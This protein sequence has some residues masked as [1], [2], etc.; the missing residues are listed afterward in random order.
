MIPNRIFGWVPQ[1]RDYRDYQLKD[2]LLQLPPLS[3]QPE[4]NLS[5]WVPSAYNQLNLGSCT[6][7][8][9]A[10]VLEFLLKKEGKEV[11]TPSRLAIYYLER[12]MEKTIN[13]DAGAIIRDGIKAC[14]NNGVFPE[15]L[16]PYLVDKF[17]IDPPKSCWAQAKHHKI[18][19]YLSVEPTINGI[20]SA[21]SLGY[22]VVFG[23]Q[24][25]S[26]F[27]DIKS[28]GIMSMPSGDY[29]GGHCVWMFGNS[30]SKAIFSCQN[31]WGTDWADNGKF[32]MPYDY[33]QYLSD[34]WTVRLLS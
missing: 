5:M 16:W 22:P 20:K 19:E 4:V 10:G 31:S 14:A 2:L 6:G 33:I 11:F 27:M 3:L 28:D 1:P 18:I 34:M 7:N 32:Y 13:E 8:G 23:M 29:E 12:E 15:T 17:K 21:L 9:I 30:D 25:F 26:N 24:V